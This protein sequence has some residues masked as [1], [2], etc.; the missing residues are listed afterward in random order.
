MA[1]TNQDSI[2]QALAQSTF[3]TPY[4]VVSQ[5]QLNPWVDALK[6]DTS[7]QPGQRPAGI[8][9]I[10]MLPGSAAPAS[11]VQP[12]LQANAVKAVPSAMD[13]PIAAPAIPVEAV[14]KM[15]N[16][17][18]APHVEAAKDRIL[19]ALMQQPHG[20]VPRAPQPTAKA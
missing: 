6:E 9:D 14:M 1:D 12:P 17:Q 11:N 13:Y 18:L 8:P 3:K 19:K 7:P 16:H 20:I 5:E 10:P 15:Y 2:I 4:G